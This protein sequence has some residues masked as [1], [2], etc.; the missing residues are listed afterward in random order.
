MYHK[1]L[2]ALENGRA[3]APLLLHASELAHHTGAALLLIHVADGFAARLFQQL[4]LA[5]SEEM[6]DDEAYLKAKAEE[7]RGRGLQVDVLLALGDPGKQILKAADEHQCDLI[8]LGSHGHGFIG[9][10][11]RGSTVHD[12]RHGSKVPVIVMPARRD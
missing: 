4:D 10:M 1:I 11:I 8:A 9:D 12:V 7:L 3:D 2:V 6:R 5:A